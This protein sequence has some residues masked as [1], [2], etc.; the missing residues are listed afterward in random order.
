MYIVL[1]GS[2]SAFADTAAV[3]AY[4]HQVKKNKRKVQDYSDSEDK[5]DEEDIFCLDDKILDLEQDKDTLNEQRRNLPLSK[6]YVYGDYFGGFEVD[7]QFTSCRE[8]FLADSGC[9]LGIINQEV[10]N[11]GYN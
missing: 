3:R 9:Q 7:E 11:S 10:D 2:V 1:L 4:V 5:S 8:F 6:Q